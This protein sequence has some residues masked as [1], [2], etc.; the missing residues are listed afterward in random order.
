MRGILAGVSKEHV[1]FFRC[2]LLFKNARFHEI[3]VYERDALFTHQGAS[4]LEISMKITELMQAIE[5]LRK[6]GWTVEPPR[7]N[8]RVAASS[9]KG[10]KRRGRPP[11]NGRRKRGRPRKNES[12]A[13]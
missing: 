2:W 5:L 1:I 9:A 10:Y 8:G 11:K 4:H 12:S 3:I 7:K 6:E 13:A